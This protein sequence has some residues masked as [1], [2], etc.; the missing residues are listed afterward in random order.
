MSETVTFK[1]IS[2]AKRMYGIPNNNCKSDK[3][4]REGKLVVT[5]YLDYSVKLNYFLLTGHTLK[6]EKFAVF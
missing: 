4:E 5:V 6:Q 1:I 3:R 2:I